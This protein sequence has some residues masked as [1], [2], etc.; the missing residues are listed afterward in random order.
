[1]ARSTLTTS[2][3]IGPFPHEGWKWAFDATAAPAGVALTIAGAVLDGAGKPVDDAV[4]EAWAPASAGAETQRPIP[5]FCRVPTDDK[6]TFSLALPAPAPGEPACY[7]TLFARGMVKHQFCAV[8]LEDD[9]QLARSALLAQVPAA[10]R[11]TLL[12]RRTS[13]NVY[14]W[15]IHLQG[16][17]ETVF[18][19]YC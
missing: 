12:A 1:M 6:G 8:F 4:L 14:R 3:T 7:V 2:Q 5:A 18:F 11:A 19:D 9:A 16:A 17:Q 15:D 10:R 13:A